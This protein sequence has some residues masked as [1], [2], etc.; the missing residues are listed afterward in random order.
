MGIVPENPEARRYR[1]LV[2]WCNRIIANAADQVVFVT[3][4][5]PLF[6]KN[7]IGE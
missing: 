4:G 3:C 5:L 6:L 1:D 2:G 7:N